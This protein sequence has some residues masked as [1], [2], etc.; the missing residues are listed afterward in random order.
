MKP[1][2]CLDPSMPATCRSPRRRLLHI[3]ETLGRRLRREVAQSFEAPSPETRA[4]ARE[5]EDELE[6]RRACPIRPAALIRRLAQAGAVFQGEYH[7]LPDCQR[8]SLA[9]LREL[10]RRREIVLCT[11]VFPAHRQRAVDAFLAGE[12]GEEELLS[13]VDFA[14]SWGFD[15]E[16]CAPIYR[17]AREEE[18]PV[19]GF[20]DAGEGGTSGLPRR[21]EI[22]ADVITRAAVSH[23]DALV[24]VIAGDFRVARRHLP[25]SCARRFAAEEIVRPAVI[26]HQNVDDIFWRLTRRSPGWPPP[27]LELAPD[28]LCLLNAS[29]IE[30]YRS[31]LEW[32]LG[33]DSLRDPA[34]EPAS[35]STPGPDGAAYRAVRRCVRAIA[36]FLGV[37]PRKLD[38]FRVYT[39]RDLSFLEDLASREGYSG[40][41]VHEVE[42]QILNDESYF[43]CR[44][45]IIYLSSTSL[46]HAAEEAA[47]YVNHKLSGWEARPLRARTDFYA[48]AVKEA[49]G[50]LGSKIVNPARVPHGE[51]D[52][53]QILR[54]ASDGSLPRSLRRLAELARFVVQHLEHER[55]RRGRR[56]RLRTIYDTPLD[57]HLG[58]THSLGYILGERLHRGLA[59]GRLDR[60]QAR[61]LFHLPLDGRGD[62]E[63]L[64]FDLVRRLR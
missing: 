8:A 35:L 36:R 2:S 56:S 7:T 61:R 17:F 24:Y 60:S 44:G 14:A 11:E 30:K 39:P 28:E 18:V 45:N 42:R 41:E 22:A 58:I 12:A 3:H 47:H 48:R 13:G 37:N 21:D 50:F 19:Y 6:L 57:L 4:Y 29:P 20:N 23:P 43:L 26:V 33:V 59:T 27:I 46:D 31:C 34:E 52:F 5:Y 55:A 63:T 62:A 53:R 38:D 9:I 10:R 16:S 64:Y 32:Q 51:A 15:W 54:H 40:A 49:L 1:T 25:A